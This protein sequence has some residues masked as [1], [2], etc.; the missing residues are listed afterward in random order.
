VFAD[1]VVQV[2]EPPALSQAAPAVREPLSIVAVGL[3]ELAVGRVQATALDL[4]DGLDLAQA[5]HVTGR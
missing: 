5:E 3:Q 4:E 1:Q 2:L